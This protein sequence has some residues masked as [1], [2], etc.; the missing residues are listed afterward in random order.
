[1]ENHPKLN[2]ND[3][4]APLRPLRLCGKSIAFLMSRHSTAHNPI[5]K[6]CP[7]L[8]IGERSESEKH[9]PSQA[10]RSFGSFATQNPFAC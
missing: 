2:E 6:R 9:D 1:M 8:F 4:R 5:P 10:H 7:R 3:L